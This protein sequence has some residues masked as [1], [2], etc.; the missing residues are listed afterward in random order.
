MPDL[1]QQ[2]IQT[3]A[4]RVLRDPNFQAMDPQQQLEVYK[5]GMRQMA[6]EATA[7]LDDGALTSMA[8]EHMQANGPGRLEGIADT[9]GGVA[10]SLPVLG[11]AIQ[12]Y[13]GRLR[14]WAQP[15]AELAT[16]GERQPGGLEGALV[17]AGFDLAELG[18]L[19]AI[20]SPVGSLAA[21]V[22]L[23]GA[24]VGVE[25]GFGAAVSQTAEAT[26]RAAGAQ[27]IRAKYLERAVTDATVGELYTL[28]KAAETGHM[29]SAQEFIVSPLAM[30]GL[31]V[32]L[33]G[34]GRVIERWGAPKANEVIARLQEIA[35]DEKFIATMGD[36]KKIASAVASQVHGMDP[37]SAGQLVYDAI[38]K[39][40][41]DD[42]QQ[43]IKRALMANPELAGSE[44]GVHIVRMQRVMVDPVF[45]VIEPTEKELKVGPPREKLSKVVYEEL[46]GPRT[47]HT[48]T[49][50]DLT[51][52]ETAAVADRFKR[53]EIH[54]SYAEGS[55]RALSAF[56]DTPAPVNVAQPETYDFAKAFD[57][58][59][60]LAASPLGR[61]ADPF[62]DDLFVRG[63]PSAEEFVEATYA[64]LYPEP[65]G[66]LL[67]GGPIPT[68][69]QGGTG[70]RG[71]NVVTPSDYTRSGPMP[72]E[73][74][75]GRVANASGESAASAEAQSWAKNNTKYAWSGGKVQAVPGINGRDYTP[76]PNEITFEVKVDPKTGKT[77]L[78]PNDVG[79]KITPAGKA[80]F[81]AEKKKIL[82]QL[83]TEAKG[84]SRA[85]KP[86]PAVVQPATPHTDPKLAE[87]QARIDRYTAELHTPVGADR[88]L[89]LRDAIARHEAE[90]K[91]LGYTAPPQAPVRIDPSLTPE[92]RIAEA[93]AGPRGKI[94]EAQPL[95]EGIPPE[96]SLPMEVHVFPNTPRE[97]ASVAG[98]TVEHSNPVT[99]EVQV[100]MPNGDVI[101]MRERAGK[102]ELVMGDVSKPYGDRMSAEAYRSYINTMRT[103]K[104]AEN[105]MRQGTTVSG[106]QGPMKSAGRFVPERDELGFAHVKERLDT[107]R[108]MYFV[109]NGMLIRVERGRNPG[110]YSFQPVQGG[111]KMAG[112][113]EVH[114]KKVQGWLDMRLDDRSVKEL[115]DLYNTTAGKRRITSRS[116]GQRIDVTNPAVADM[117]REILRELD[118]RLG[119]KLAP[120]DEVIKKAK[121][122]SEDGTIEAGLE[123]TRRCP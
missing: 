40:L 6:P 106:Q 50:K 54:V 79:A 107:G 34:M 57:T 102:L 2:E 109:Q 29:P 93:T 80:R 43:L 45:K 49:L 81:A 48:Q 25:A 112:G 18:L 96:P 70:A 27:A 110:A 113:G 69:E 91:R 100:R 87:H 38:T 88:Q 20:A 86:S 39:V 8:Q 67:P 55:D 73:G 32:G 21:R 47:R 118:S 121:V 3:R 105:P 9:L 115:A 108:P 59:N 22:G 104:I 36:G 83:E 76:K 5:S 97:G 24:A 15:V 64:E 1:D 82:K 60:P 51:T 95:P 46:T 71:M 63:A 77:T 117:R 94:G 58:F 7:S 62:V 99:G 26:V 72:P 17:G 33:M 85:T 12:G 30:A 52:G 65:T 41:P 75:M 61:Q 37:E 11:G 122:A 16:H 66:Q 56:R 92:P 119:T 116:A 35:P 90:M 103:Y 120:A 28:S 13:Q 74:T 19:T 14:E 10:E 44:L 111:S 84:K 78:T 53:G 68:A 101:P 98:G 123:K 31:G 42:Q 89:Q 23:K 114:L 4:Q